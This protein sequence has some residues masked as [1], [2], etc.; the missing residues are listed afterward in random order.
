MLMADRCGSPCPRRRR[1]L[2]GPCGGAARSPTPRGP[3]PKSASKRR[4]Q[5]VLP[6]GVS[7]GRLQGAPPR[8]APKGRAGRRSKG[9]LTMRA[10][11][12]PRTRGLQP[13]LPTTPLAPHVLPQG[14]PP[15]RAKGAPHRCLMQGLNHF[16]QPKHRRPRTTSRRAPSQ[17]DCGGTFG[18]ALVSVP[19]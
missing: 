10:L 9:D 6:S 1:P 4:R 18:G 7:K 5:G 16:P 12:V 11:K 15:T 2:D 19:C 14:V 17:L 13:V 3:R 8:G